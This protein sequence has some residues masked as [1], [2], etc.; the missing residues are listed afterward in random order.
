MERRDVYGGTCKQNQRNKEPW[1]TG[2]KSAVFME[3]GANRNRSPWKEE[4]NVYGNRCKQN[5]R[6]KEP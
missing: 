5:K 3:I 6:N 4:C 2:K 1:K